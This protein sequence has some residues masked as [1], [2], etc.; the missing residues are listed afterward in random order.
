MGAGLMPICASEIAPASAWGIFQSEIRNLG[1]QQVLVGGSE[2][3]A[4]MSVEF[5]NRSPMAVWHEGGPWEPSLGRILVAAL[6]RPHGGGFATW[7]STAVRANFGSV[8][9][10]GGGWDRGG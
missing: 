9:R 1:A 2:F 6:P 7:S 5:N 3:R 4:H 8:G 10:A